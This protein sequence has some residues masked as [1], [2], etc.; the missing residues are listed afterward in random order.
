MGAGQVRETVFEQ[1]RQEIP[2]STFCVVE[3]FRE[4][5]DPV[6][7]QATLYAERLSQK[8]ILVGAGGSGI[9]RLGEAARE[10]TEHFLGCPVY[11][12][13]WVK[14]LPGWRRKRGHLARFGFRVPESDD[15]SS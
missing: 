10:K 14:A 7:V 8:R 12:D 6:Y 1:F 13:L 5:Q 9:K 11:L 15:R 2:Y 3:E 4:D